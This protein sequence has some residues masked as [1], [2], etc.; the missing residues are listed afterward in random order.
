VPE[1]TEGPYFVD[2]MLERADIRSEPDSGEVKEGTPLVLTLNVLA[3][4]GGGCEPLEGALVDV[5][6]CDAEGAYAGFDDTAEGFNTEGERWLRGYLTT[7]VEGRVEFTTIYPGWYTGRATH[8]HFKVRK[9]NLEFTS[10]WFFDDVLS[11]AVHGSGGAYAEKGVDGRLPNNRDG[12]YNQSA[13]MLELAVQPTSDGY[14]ASFDIGIQ[15]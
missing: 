9:D 15:T 8:I 2:T 14:A 6:H 11:D 12:I 10:Q 1:L 13:G 5:W 7:D 4:S 3:V